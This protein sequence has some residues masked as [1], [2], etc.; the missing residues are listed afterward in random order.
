MKLLRYDNPGEEKPVLLDSGGSI[1][2]L[3]DVVRA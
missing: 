2:D 1:R 3:T